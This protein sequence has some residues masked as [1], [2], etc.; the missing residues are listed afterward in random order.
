MAARYSAISGLEVG[1]LRCRRETGICSK[2]EWVMT[3][4]SQS[5]VAQRATNSLRRS[6]RVS[7]S[8]AMSTLAWG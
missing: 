6:G 1:R 5:P 2:A 8:V 7:S 3:M 4:A